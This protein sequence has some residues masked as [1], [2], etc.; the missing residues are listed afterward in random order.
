MENKKSLNLETIV[1]ILIAITAVAAAVVTWRASIVSDAS[2]DADYGGLRS[3]MFAEEA[4]AANAVNGYEH[5]GAYTTYA[6]YTSMGNTLADYLGENP[7]LDPQEAFL[8]DRQRAEYLDLADANNDL[9]PTRFI[10]RDGSYGLQRELDEMWADSAKA[11]DLNADPQFKEADD[12]RAKSDK[13]LA[14]LTLISIGLVFFT[15]IELAG[16]RMKVV[17]A[18]LATL[19]AIVGTVAAVIFEMAK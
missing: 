2:G 12:L 17:L 8:L 15:L 16:D 6:R 4:R 18:A 14:T 3:S 10:N 9:F 11:K 1:A 19:C 13:M 7:E 5:Y